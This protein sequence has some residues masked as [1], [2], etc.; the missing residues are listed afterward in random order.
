MK[1]K[2]TFYVFILI[3][4]QKIDTLNAQ[5]LWEISGNGLEKPS[6]LYG[7]MHISDKRVFD[8]DPQL[9]PNFD[10]TDAFAGEMLLDPSMMFEVMAHLFMPSDT[11]LDMLL[12]DEE[13]Q[14]VKLHLGKKMGMM[15][16]FADKMKPIFTSVFLAEQ[17]AM[18]SLQSS[19]KPPLD[20]YFQDIAREKGKEVIGLETL[21]EQLQAFNSIP[22]SYQAKILLQEVENTGKPKTRNQ[23]EEMI[24]IYQ[25]ED[26]D[27]LY[28]FASG[29]MSEDINKQLLTIRNRKMAN[30]AD[31][32]IKEKQ[33]SLFIAV[34]A[35]HLPAENGLIDLFQKMGY[36]VRP[37][38]KKKQ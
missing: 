4:S 36:E 27:K 14:K 26:L 23:M 2:I 21:A 10:K 24:R 25:S 20:M 31:K 29:Q 37:L 33:K 12:T 15:N 9:M 11:T 32:L 22:L 1:K 28:S 8:F 7:T 34:G 13:Y 18:D 5:L 3:F 17:G 16:M 6:Y 38:S 30:R 35:A 19:G